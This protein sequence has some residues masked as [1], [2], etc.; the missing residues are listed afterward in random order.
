MGE[1][2]GVSPPV[3]LAHGRAKL[4]L[5]RRGDL[6]ELAVHAVEHAVAERLAG[7]GNGQSRGPERG[8]SLVARVIAEELVDVVL[9]FA[10]AGDDPP[11]AV[12]GG[13]VPEYLMSLLKRR[14]LE[15]VRD[16]RGRVGAVAG[17]LAARGGTM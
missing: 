3:L 14:P 1:R 9:Q 11:D 7:Q 17:G 2:R 4:F 16:D 6:L 10:G 15:D 5:D 8:L 12:V 13:A